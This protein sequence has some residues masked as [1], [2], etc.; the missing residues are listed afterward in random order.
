MIEY[1]L[2]AYRAL[3]YC[4]RNTLNFFFREE[5]PEHTERV[6][7]SDIPWL[8]LGTTLDDVKYT[9]TQDVNNFITYGTLV[10]PEYL[11]DITGYDKDVTWMYLHPEE[12]EEREFP[13]EGFL[14][15]HATSEANNNS[16][17]GYTPET[18]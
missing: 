10:T 3:F 7:V 2:W 11:S 4:R 6:H 1:L 5:E 13:S 17:S 15:Q 16:E 18:D 9:V 8:W 12:L 14:I